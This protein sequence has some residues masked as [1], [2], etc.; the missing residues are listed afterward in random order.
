MTMVEVGITVAEVGITV[1]VVGSAVKKVE[2]L[3]TNEELET[4]ALELGE[5]VAFV[6]N[7]IVVFCKTSLDLTIPLVLNTVVRFCDFKVDVNKLE[8]IKGVVLVRLT[9]VVDITVL[10]PVN[11]AVVSS[12]LDF[13][14]LLLFVKTKLLEFNTLLCMSVT[15]LE[16]VTLV[17]ETATKLLAL[18]SKT[19]EEAN[20]VS[21]LGG[22][23]EDVL[24]KRL[25]K[26]ETN[27]EV[28]TNTVDETVC[29]EE[30]MVV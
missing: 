18:G 4:T 14:V 20:T 26:L 2:L 10:L 23:N 3:S 25:L 27:V 8:F 6:L 13:K 24:V 11:I 21:L 15:V 28:T 17:F 12:V 1:T 7:T 9:S 29:V 19:V 16:N 22:T 5:T 30:I